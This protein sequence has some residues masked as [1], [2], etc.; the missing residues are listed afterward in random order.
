M[1]SH[2]FAVQGLRSGTAGHARCT[3]LR[4]PSHTPHATQHNAT[5]RNSYA[6]TN[7]KHFRMRI[8]G[9]VTMMQKLLL[10]K[11]CWLDHVMLDKYIIASPLAPLLSFL[12][13]Q[14]NNATHCRETGLDPEGI[15]LRAA[16]G[17]EAA[18]YLFPGYWVWGKLIQNFA[19]TLSI[20]I[21]YLYIFYFL[22]SIF[23]LKCAVTQ[24]FLYMC[25]LFII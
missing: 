4:R 11:Q 13:Q 7:R 12:T 19:G 22:F 24:R 3:L 23:I 21:F 9:T 6:T 5:Q 1:L 17:L 16:T 14:M 8:W 10:D 15:K 2:I 20:S 18:D 25:Y